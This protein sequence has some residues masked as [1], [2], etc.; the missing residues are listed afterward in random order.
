M[1]SLKIMSFEQIISSKFLVFPRIINIVSFIIIKREEVGF[2]L[3]I[4]LKSFGG[5]R[6]VNFQV[7]ILRDESLIQFPI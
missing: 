1:G 2:P 7:H 4:F 6:S 5:Y 3:R